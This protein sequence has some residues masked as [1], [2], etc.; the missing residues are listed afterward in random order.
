MDCRKNT[1]D[2]KFAN[3]HIN[4][5]NYEKLEKICIDAGFSEIYHSGFGS[6]LASINKHK[7][8]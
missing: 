7:I 1:F 8:I 2:E 5:W 3:Y 6:H 4:F